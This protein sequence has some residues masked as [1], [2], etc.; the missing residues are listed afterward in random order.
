MRIQYTPGP[1]YPTKSYDGDLAVNNHL[2]FASKYPVAVV[3]GPLDEK[4][5]NARLIAAAPDMLAALE[6]IA[7]GCITRPPGHCDYAENRT[8]AQI[9]S[10]ARAAI[11]K[12]RGEGA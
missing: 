3:Y 1:W 4:A 6:E 10:I 2:E 5:A 12:A 7:A 8:K 9:E 11:T